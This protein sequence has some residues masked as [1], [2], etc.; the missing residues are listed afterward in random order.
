[1][2]ALDASAFLAFLFREKG[3]ERVGAVLDQACL[4]TVNLAEVIGRFV[5]DGRGR[6]SY[7]I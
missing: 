1:M 7:V 2:I 3:Y 5:Q 4:S 6:A